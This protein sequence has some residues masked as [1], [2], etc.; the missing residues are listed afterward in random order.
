MATLTN[1]VFPINALPLTLSTL[2]EAK[3]E[4]AIEAI[5]AFARDC[6]FPAAADPSLSFEQAAVV[7]QT[8][9]SLKTI[10]TTLPSENTSLEMQVQAALRTITTN[11]YKKDGLKERALKNANS[12]KE[13]IYIHAAEKLPLGRLEIDRVLKP[14]LCDWDAMLAKAKTKEA[15]EGCIQSAVDFALELLKA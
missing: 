7:K 9:K 10:I 8:L 5:S 12:L 1:G 2:A 13:I 3:P 11:L 4:V 15:K 14:Y 6:I